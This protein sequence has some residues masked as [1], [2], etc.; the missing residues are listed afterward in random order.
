MP[1][2]AQCR[3]SV[4]EVDTPDQ[5][6]R[7][8]AILASAGVKLPSRIAYVPFDFEASD[9]EAALASAL[10]ARGFQRDAGTLFIWEGVIGYIDDAAIDRSLQFMAR[11]GGPRSRL[12]FT[13]GEGSFAPE[14]VSTRTRRAGFS[15]CEEVG[16]DELW[17]RYLAG[18][19]HP[20]AWVVKIATAV[21]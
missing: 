5:M 6:Q 20:N 10:E 3:A 8:R 17:R 13:Y 15:S 12:V 21:V 19:P 14:T 16:S 9:F 2:I 11:T 1:E 18:D 4:Y 7:K